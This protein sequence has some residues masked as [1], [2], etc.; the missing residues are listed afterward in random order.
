MIAVRKLPPSAIREDDPLWRKFI[1][2]PFDPSPAPEQE[3]RGLEEAKA[4]GFVDGATV[5][6]EIAR[7]AY[8]PAPPP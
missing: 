7:R 6:A 1:E 8:P 4:G 3:V 2:S 5:S